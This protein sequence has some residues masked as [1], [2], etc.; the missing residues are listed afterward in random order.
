MKA[1]VAAIWVACAAAQSLPA[2]E[3][4]L[5]PIVVT[6]TFELRQGP[7][8]TDL[9]TRHLLKQIETRQAMEEIVARSPWYYSRLWN[10]F[11]MQLQSSSSDS[12][13]FFM[14]RYLSLDNQHAEEMLR[15]SEKQSLFD[16]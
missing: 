7:S 8:V 4:E 11:P 9:F 5:A 2:Q 10:Y 6:G 1:A 13:L 3:A 14:P 12:A 15:K 16:H